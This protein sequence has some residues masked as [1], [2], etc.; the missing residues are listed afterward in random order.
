MIRLVGIDV[1]GTLLDS[2][3]HLAEE[4]RDAIAAAVA[5]GIHV[6]LVTGRSYPFARPVA[7]GLPPSVTLIVSNGAV[8]RATDGTTLARRLLDRDVARSVLA[9][10]EPYR[11]HAAL[12]FDRDVAGQIIFETMDWEHPGRRS[13]WAKNRAL[14]AR[15]VPLEDALVEDPIQVMFNGDVEVIRDLAERLR[16]EADGF[17]VSLTEYVH[18]NFSLV[19][20]TSPSAT[21]G[22]ALAWRAAQLGLTRDEVMAI[23]D[24]YNDVEMLEFAGTP[25]VMDNAVEGLK[26]RGWAVTGHQDE[27]GVAEA[28]RNY[29]LQP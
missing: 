10:T 13:Y 21:K 15:A 11:H 14:I 2:R 9:A 1:D 16:A 26:H 19:D 4:N 28:I 8:E 20:I 25:V 7:D 24:N 22:Q 12:I 18:R 29:A 27:A 6:A 17:S 23:G 3:G 5:A